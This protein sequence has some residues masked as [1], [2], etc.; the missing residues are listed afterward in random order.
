MYKYL[1]I[2][3]FF[4]FTSFNLNSKTIDVK[5]TKFHIELVNQGYA[6]R[7]LGTYSLQMSDG[8]LISV[9]AYIWK[10]LNNSGIYSQYKNEQTKIVVGFKHVFSFLGG[11]LGIMYGFFT[12]FIS[13]K[14]EEQNK[15]NIEINRKI[16]EGFDNMNSNF[17]EVYTGIGTLN[18]NV[19]G[20]NN[21]F[22]DLNKIRTDEGGGF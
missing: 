2:I 1:L 6:Y 21:R 8:S 19:E 16:T 15:V 10:R 3:I 18:G 20:I 7:T 12:L 4:L 9:E 14:F 5:I 13:P 22:R 11:I 17:K